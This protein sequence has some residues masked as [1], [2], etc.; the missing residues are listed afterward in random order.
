MRVHLVVG[1]RSQCVHHHVLGSES[2]E[3]TSII[4]VLI[5]IVALSVSGVIS[6]VYYEPLDEDEEKVSP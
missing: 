6:T 1:M 3:A 5:V 4:T 2:M